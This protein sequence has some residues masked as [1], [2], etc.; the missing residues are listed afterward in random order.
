MCLAIV[1][2]CVSW[3]W[4]IDWLLSELMNMM[5]IGQAANSNVYSSGHLCDGQLNIDRWKLSESFCL[6]S[7]LVQRTL[8]MFIKF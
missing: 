7:C 5:M 1:I 2:Y 6:I 3:N 4:L 8:L